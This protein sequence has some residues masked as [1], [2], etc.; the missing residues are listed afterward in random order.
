MDNM[1]INYQSLYKIVERPEDGY[2][3]KV[4]MRRNLP[5]LVFPCL[6]FFS[7]V[8]LKNMHRNLGHPSVEKHMKI[9]E[10]ADLKNLDENT[11]F[12]LKNLV[13]HCKICQLT[14]AKP[15]RFLFSIKDDITGEFNHIIEIDVCYLDDGNILHIICNGTGFQSGKFLS[16][17]SAA[18]AWRTLRQS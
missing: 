3:E 9:I 6:G 2:R 10:Q 13:K 12:R 1:G 8:Q 4:E 18:T 11:R 7:D 17:M 16:D 15:R 5:Y 14:G